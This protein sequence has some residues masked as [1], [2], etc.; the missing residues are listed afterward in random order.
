MLKTVIKYSQDF[1]ETFGCFAL[2]FFVSI[3]AVVLHKVS[4]KIDESLT[5][6]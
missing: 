6:K 3:P 2:L 4:G 5:E 1:H